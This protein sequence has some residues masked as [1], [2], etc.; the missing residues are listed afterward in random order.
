MV[1]SKFLHKNI[2]LLP[3]RKKALVIACSTFIVRCTP[4]K[5]IQNIG[6]CGRVARLSSAKAPTAV[7]IRSGP[8][9][10]GLQRCDPFLFLF[11]FALPRL[12]FK[13]VY[14]LDNSKAL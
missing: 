4:L 1:R 5:I 10:K 14:S 2:L 11:H 8:L 9:G 13:I 6:S 3:R 12:S 7:R